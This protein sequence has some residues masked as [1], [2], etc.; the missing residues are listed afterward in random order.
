MK[1]NSIITLL[2]I[3]QFCSAQSLETDI[4]TCIQENLESINFDYNKNIYE[5]DSI[6]LLDSI[7]EDNNASKKR[8]LEIISENG[9]IDQTR[10]IE[11]VIL[12]QVGLRTLE[13]CISIQNYK[14]DRIDI[15]PEFRMFQELKWLS[16]EA[17]KDKD[18]KKLQRERA[19][20]LLKY[21]PENENELWDMILVEYFYLL[22][23]TTDMRK[24]NEFYIKQKK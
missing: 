14:E 12:E 23:E 11:N 19:M 6:F 2:L 21:F 18:Y 15:M 4:S 5:L 13:Y 1:I 3:A 17:S 9:K 16:L 20:T 24:I 8:Q 10:S 7:Y 22:T